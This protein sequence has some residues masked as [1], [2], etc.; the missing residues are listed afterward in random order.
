[1]PSTDLLRFCSWGGWLLSTAYW[2][3]GRRPCC[4]RDLL[5]NLADFH[6]GLF[7]LLSA[8]VLVR[9][10]QTVKTPELRQQMKWVTRGTALAVVPYF[11]L[12]SVPRLSGLIPEHYVDLA[13]FPLVLIPISF[14]YAIHRYRLMDVDIIF[15]RGVTYTL[16]TAC[17]IGLYATFVVVVGE[18][19]GAGFEPLSTVARVVATIVAA[20][21]FAPI[22]D[23]F[24]VWLDKFFYRDR[25][26]VR[27]T[28]IDFGRTLGSEVHLE[29]ML[30]RIL[31]QLVA[32]PI[33]QP[34]RDFYRRSNRSSALCAPP[35]DWHH[36]PLER[37]F[38]IPEIG[39]RAALLFFRNRSCMI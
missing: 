31:D 17:I 12:Q 3:Y 16:A 24:Q 37:G 4:L 20:L 6:F 8:V 34:G 9:T 15:K 23:Q 5:D 1:M 13:I 14:G 21:L 2:G 10:Y 22:K 27:Q 32:A 35:C 19:L 36:F 25:Y 26:D 38:L 7:F 11:S 33:C 28:L 18:L 29:K 30:D 39:D